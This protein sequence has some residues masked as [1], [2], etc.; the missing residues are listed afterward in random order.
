M[1]SNNES[2]DS[3]FNKI[4]YDK[5]EWLK[6]TEKSEK[7]QHHLIKYPEGIERDHLSTTF[8]VADFIGSPLYEMKRLGRSELFGRGR[9]GQYAAE[10]TINQHKKLLE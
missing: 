4:E 9:L 5:Y 1:Q 6:E 8:S 10:R 2:F 7:E 3:Y